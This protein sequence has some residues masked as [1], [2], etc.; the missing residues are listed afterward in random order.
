MNVM[1]TAH[2]ECV[3]RSHCVSLP[4]ILV[5]GPDVR[6]YTTTLTNSVIVYQNIITIKYAVHHRVFF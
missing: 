4:T 3:E 1:V 5:F 6:K 2:G